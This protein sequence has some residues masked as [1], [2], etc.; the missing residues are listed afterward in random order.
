MHARFRAVGAS[1]IAAAL[2]LS[3]C[4]DSTGPAGAPFDPAHAEAD[5]AA[6]S[7]LLDNQQLAAF[8]AMSAYF[9]LSGAPLATISS[10]RAMISSGSAPRVAARQTTLAATEGLAL[11]AGA[12]AAPSFAVLPTDVFG[13]TFVFDESTESYVESDRSGAPANGVRFILYAIDPV[14]GIPVVGTEVGYADLI[15]TSVGSQTAAGLRLLVVSGATTYLDYAFSATGTQNSVLL[16]VEGYLTDG[17]TQ[18]NFGIDATVAFTQQQEL[19]IDVAFGFTVP[20][21]QFSVT[22]SVNGTVGE[23]EGV[24]HV[25]LTIV[26]GGTNVRFVVDE[27]AS[28]LSA[29]VFVNN[30]IFATVTGDPENPSVLGAGG[31]EL[32]DE[33]I[34]AL[35]ELLVVA[36]A[37]FEFFGTLL[38]P[39]NNLTG[40]GV[41]P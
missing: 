18:L 30:K 41:L 23:S 34:A 1:C 3:G 14:T 12:S 8:S 7:G 31:E 13:T 28:T 21:R 17:T 11:K 33:E 16:G 27:D 6:F 2:L 5:V 15:D 9:T 26:S 20:S 19:D 10:A 36:D 37:A 4:S 29:T 22:G 32:T 25:T 38:E 40:G 24:G 39:I 35:A